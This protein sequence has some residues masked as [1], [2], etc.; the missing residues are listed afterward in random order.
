MAVAFLVQIA[1]LK[2]LIGSVLLFTG[3][4]CKISQDGVL[5]IAFAIVMT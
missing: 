1:A 3:A 4:Q 2:A 5:S